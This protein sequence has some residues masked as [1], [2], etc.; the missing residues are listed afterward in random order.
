MPYA[1]HKPILGLSA[2]QPLGLSVATPKATPILASGA[3]VM[4]ES[5]EGKGKLKQKNYEQ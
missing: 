4:N 5:P 3:S 2:G 1:H